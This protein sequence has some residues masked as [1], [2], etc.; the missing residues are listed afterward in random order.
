MRYFALVFVIAVGV[1]VMMGFGAFVIE[2][3]N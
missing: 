1:V 3:G 2:W